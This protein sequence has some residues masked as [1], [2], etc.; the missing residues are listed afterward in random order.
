MTITSPSAGALL[1]I[2][3]LVEI[4]VDAS[5]PDGTIRHVSFILDERVMS[6]DDAPPYSWSWDTE[7]VASYSH[8]LRAVAEDNDG[9]EAGA[10][11]QVDTR[12]VYHRPEELDDGWQTASLEDVGMDSSVLEGM[13]NA[14]YMH[15]EHL[16][17]SIIIIREG[18]LV[19]EKYFPGRAHAT[20]GAYP[21]MYDRDTPHILSST[22]KSFTSALLGIAIDQGMIEG[23][24][25]PLSDFFPEFPW[26]AQGGKSCPLG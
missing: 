16:V 21:V 2:G 9:A 19:F 14:L 8:Q 22:T 20:Q 1:T 5:D 23:V 24:N 26:L 11:L 7:H 4:T 25:Q 15:T 12:W 17:E 6:R 3:D 13:V 10:S 18:K